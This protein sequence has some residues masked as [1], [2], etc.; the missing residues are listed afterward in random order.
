MVLQAVD[1]MRKSGITYIGDIPW[2]THICGFYESEQDLAKFV[3][4][5]LHAGLENN[6]YCIWVISDLADPLEA[7]AMLADTFQDFTNSSSKIEILSQ[8][9]WYEQYNKVDEETI[10]IVAQKLNYAFAQGCDGLRICGDVSRYEYNWR[11]IMNLEFKSFENIEMFNVVALA[12]YQLSSLNVYEIVDISSNYKFAFV[13]TGYEWKCSETVFEY[14]R[15]STISELA[16]SVVHE[17][18]NP[19]TSVIALVQLLQTK[20]E[21]A[22]YNQ[23]F[24]TIVDELHRANGIITEYLSLASEKKDQ[25]QIVNLNSIME[26]ILPLLKAEAT[27]T[28][29][30]IALITGDLYE[31]EVNSQEIRQ[32]ILNIARN[33]LEAMQKPGKLTIKTY[34]EKDMV[35]LEI[36][37][38][39]HGIPAEIINEIGRP[40]FT[41]KQTGTGLGLSVS[42]K[43]IAKH[44]GKIDL[45]TSEQ[46]TIFKISFPALDNNSSHLL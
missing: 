10:N 21:L 42:Q 34:L 11:E 23:L 1:N 24:T 19:M 32:V 33:G 22:K 18:R 44:N 16:A 35:I 5:Y 8:A 25:T 41:T 20:D 6:E 31:I 40:F 14:N 26:S 9:E 12:S 15:I 17:I 37:D 46:G 13:E 29:N 3:I 36:A 28:N 38:Q 30:R 39:G 27:K 4:P 45:Q 43:I 2:G 7:E